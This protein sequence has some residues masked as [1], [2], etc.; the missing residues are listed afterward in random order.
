MRACFCAVLFSLVLSA[1][2]IN[3]I[4][5][6]V[7]SYIYP[8]GTAWNNIVTAGSAKVKIALINPLNG[9]VLL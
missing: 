7:P 2:L 5:V 6:A 9:K 8:G 3:A 1:T 4:E